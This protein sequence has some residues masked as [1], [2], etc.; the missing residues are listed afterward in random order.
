MYQRLVSDR[1]RSTAVPTR[2]QRSRRR[3]ER[4]PHD[5]LSRLH[6]RPHVITSHGGL[7]NCIKKNPHSGISKCER[8]DSNLHGLPHWILNPALAYSNVCNDHGLQLQPTSGCTLGCTD[9]PESALSD[10]RLVRLVE[11]WP[12]LPDQIRDAIVSLAAFQ[13]DDV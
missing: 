2:S 3:R 12:T 1:C 4:L 5:R 8:Q 10:P 13:V 11:A 6:P 7:P 9:L